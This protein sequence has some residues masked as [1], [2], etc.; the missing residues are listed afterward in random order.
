MWTK[1]Q[2][3]KAKTT[4]K[5]ATLA[6]ACSDY[7]SKGEVNDSE[8]RTRK[9]PQ[10]TQSFSAGEKETAHHRWHAALL[11]TRESDAAAGRERLGRLGRSCIKPK[12]TTK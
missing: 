4:F 10:K 1:N 9:H 11:K 8:K 2:G 7:L 12:T 6:G 3:E 5:N